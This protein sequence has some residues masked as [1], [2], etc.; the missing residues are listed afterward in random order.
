MILLLTFDSKSF[1]LTDLN[2]K[3]KT[4][5]IS[6]LMGDVLV[7]VV[8]RLVFCIVFDSHGEAGWP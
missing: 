4:D 2:G 6:V 5:T 8:I 7:L 3:Q 1:F